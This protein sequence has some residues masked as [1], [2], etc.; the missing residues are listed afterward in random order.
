MYIF[1]SFQSSE[2]NIH[3]LPGQLAATRKLCHLYT[4]ESPDQAQ[5]IIYSQ[6]QVLLL[7]R[8]GDRGQEGH[9]LEAISQLYIT[10]GTER[11]VCV[12][13]C[14]TETSHTHTCLHTVSFKM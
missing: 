12:C 7:R 11:S 3:S 6:H 9:A 1:W 8:S 10:L 5:C 13:V 2:I 4:L 14:R